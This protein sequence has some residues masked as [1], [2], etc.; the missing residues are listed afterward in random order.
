MADHVGELDDRDTGFELFDDESVAQI[1]NLGTSNACDA[2]VA[3]DRGSDIADQERV[4]SLGDKEGGIFGFG[5]TSH[6]FFDC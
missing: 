2:E 1:I 5:T 6:V 4:A 3:I